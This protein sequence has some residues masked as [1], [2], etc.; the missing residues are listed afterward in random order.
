MRAIKRR[1][2]SPAHAQQLW[3]ELEA[4]L[5]K[6]YHSPDLEGARVVLFAVAAH[7]LSG[8]PVWLML[9]APPGSMKTELLE[10][11]QAVGPFNVHVVDSV[12][13]NTF[14]SGKL[15][16][17]RQKQ[18]GQHGLLQRIGDKGIIVVP[19]FSTILSMSSEKRGE[20][21]AQLRRIYDGHLRREFGTKENLTDKR[22]WRGRI[23][24]LVAATP[25]VDR[26]YAVLN[27]LGERF[28]MVR[29]PRPRGTEA[30]HRAMNQDQSAAR[31]ELESVYRQL[32]EGLP[33]NAEPEI[34]VEMQHQLAALAEFTVHARTHVPRNRNNREI[35]YVPEPEAPTRL[36][37]QLAQ[38]M[39]GS[40][41]LAGRREAAKEDFQVARRAAW[42]SIP[43]ARRIV[44]EQAMGKP[45]DLQRSSAALSY[46]REEL[47]QL[48]LLDT[49]GYFTE[50]A[51]GWL[52]QAGVS[53]HVTPYQNVHT[54]SPPRADGNTDSP[55]GVGGT[56]REKSCTE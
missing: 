44:L 37:Q 29:L 36:A 23:T 4:V 56:V 20:V 9:V 25:D 47:T 11:L 7:C 41:L 53:L 17:S 8:H 10:P 33:Q 18:K 24:C 38:L 30:A 3:N 12:T 55:I 40:A 1:S 39:K 27:T 6:H 22:E 34:P 2:E 15:D 28:V 35:E 19:D 51:A 14:I 21:L 32:L 26:H 52:R 49:S 54:T 13:P 16:E 45:A 43:K 5:Q 42:D 50:Q 48:G 46:A 31:K